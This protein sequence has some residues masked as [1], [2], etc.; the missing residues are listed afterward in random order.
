MRLIP[1]RMMTSQDSGYEWP[2]CS[3]GLHHVVMINP[4]RRVR[5]YPRNHLDDTGII[6]R[7]MAGK[8]R[9]MVGNSIPEDAQ[10]VQG[11]MDVFPET[12]DMRKRP[13]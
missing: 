12:P 5:A 1:G 10:I 9:F 6:G 4:G 11:G 2:L 7:S 3:G 13:I 8:N